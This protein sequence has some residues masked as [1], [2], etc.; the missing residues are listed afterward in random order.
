MSNERGFSAPAPGALTPA[1]DK[2]TV[3][4]ADGPLGTA[5]SSTSPSPRDHV[6]PR[7]NWSAPDHGLLTWTF[8]PAAAGVGITIVGGTLY[9]ARVHL[10]VA[11]SVTNIVCRVSVGGGTLT[12]GRCF[13]A[14]YTAAGALIGV[15]ADQSGSWNS[16]G[17][18]TMA[19]AGGPFAQAAADYYVGLWWNGTT[20]PTFS[21]GT[22]SGGAS[23]GLSAPNLRFATA[24]TGLTTTA[25]AN[26]GAQVT[27]GSIWLGLS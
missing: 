4:L 13:G 27:A 25:P 8:D 5:G 20:S 19:L 1:T 18:K 24:D 16:T 6:H 12:A 3:P 26:F 11:G 9:L 15:T 22:T 7:T 23:A 14:L 17:T 2:T 21:G 10:P